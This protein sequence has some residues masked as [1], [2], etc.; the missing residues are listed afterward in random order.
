MTRLT[1]LLVGSVILGVFA[2]SSSERLRSWVSR[3][4]LSFP[5]LHDFC[6]Q[7]VDQLLSNLDRRYPVLVA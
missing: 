2:A 7:F 5:K 6:V 4:L 3:R 1:F